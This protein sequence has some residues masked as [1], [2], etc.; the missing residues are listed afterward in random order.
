[1]DENTLYSLH[2]RFKADHDVPEGWYRSGHPMDENAWVVDLDLFIEVTMKA[3]EWEALRGGPF[4]L[5]I[6]EEEYEVELPADASL[7]ECW[8]MPSCGLFE[9]AP[10]V[11]EEQLAEAEDFEE[12]TE[13]GR[14]GD[15]YV[16]PIVADDGE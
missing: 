15:V 9:A 7:D 13:L 4:A 6:G 8:V 3:E 5:S 1:M 16:I 12:D 10:G 14:F 11:T 2:A